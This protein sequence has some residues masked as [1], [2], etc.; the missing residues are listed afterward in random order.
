MGPLAREDLL[1]NCV[2]QVERSVSM[3]ARVLFGGRILTPTQLEPVVI[4]DVTPDMPVFQE[5]TF[6][7]IFPIIKVDNE[8]EAINVANNSNYGLGAVIFTG[9]VN[10]AETEIVDRIQSGMVFVNEV[11]KS[12]IPVPFGGVKHSGLGR[13]LGEAGIKEFTTLKTVFLRS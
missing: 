7:P 13:E 2:S 9:D 1:E 4:V 6:G 12:M 10:R 5:E 11:T 3:G 8:E